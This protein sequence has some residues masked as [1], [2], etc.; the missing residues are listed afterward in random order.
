MKV[1]K[2]D[3]RVVDYDQSKI[4]IAIEKANNEVLE[5]EK[6]N[7]NDIKKI[8]KYIEDLN[9]K[10]ILV[11]DIQD[12]IEQKLMELGKYEL[13]KKYIVYRYTRAL[14]RK[15]NTTDESIL[16]LI[17]NKNRFNELQNKS[18]MD[19]SRQRD[20]VT[21]EVSKD[22]T[23]RILL[24]EKI[25]NAWKDGKL[26]FHRSEYFIQP[27]I[28]D[29]LIN[30]EDML[31]NGTIINGKLIETPKSFQ[32]ACMV[33]SQIL[34][35]LAG[36]Q[37]GNIRVDTS[38]LGKYLRKS[39][40][41]WKREVDENLAKKKLASELSTGIQVLL[42]QIN[43]LMA[44]NQNKL[45]ILYL[46]VGQ[47]N[48]YADENAQIIEEILKQ[49]SNGILGENGNSVDIENLKLIYVLIEEKYDYLT[50]YAMKC[51]LKRNIIQYISEKSMKESFK[52]SGKFSQG[53]VSI[54]LPQIAIIADGDENIFW[55][56]LEQRLELCKEALL[57][58][59]YALLGTIAD[60][61]P[62]HWK[63]G[64]IARLNSEERIDKLL[65]NGNSSISLGY[66]G[67]YETTK[68]I[69]GV[70]YTENS[71]YDFAMKIMK[72]LKEK[73]QEWKKD[74]NINFKLYEP[75]NNDVGRE[76][77]SIDKE[78][79][80]IIK[81]ITDKEYY[82]KGFNIPEENEMNSVESLRFKHKFLKNEPISCE[83]VQS[84]YE[85]E[86]MLKIIK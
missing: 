5:Q 25:I 72:T 33:L 62:I 32:T 79:F 31:D 68:L 53:A 20:L 26:Y 58:R 3:G 80:G 82:T 48:E 61:S 30:I 77:L 54:N 51:S 10:R 43:T 83:R 27:I 35:V 52:N 44:L 75:S 2:R 16:G 14:I 70:S 86:E 42:Y 64:A 28:C 29:T 6:A 17:R 37:Y 55:Q 76:F 24:P 78:K 56:E 34:I 22:L 84:I 45:I 57:C 66:V 73:V 12:I 41:R 46:N 1:I 71:G 13:A 50:E 18:L 9:K 81:D 85:I 4:Q 74:T 47:E 39:Y 19:I 36:N 63:S 49:T 40:E 7:K 38:H 59:H 23:K 60:I 69:K 11:E 8:I 21:G 15:S 67:V 65:Y